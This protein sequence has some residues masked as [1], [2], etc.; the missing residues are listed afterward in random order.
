M[1]S[2]LM[3]A[4]DGEVPTKQRA[5]KTTTRV[6]SPR[7]CRNL[8]RFQPCAGEKRERAKR[9]KAI[10]AKGR[11]ASVGSL[12]PAKYGRNSKYTWLDTTTTLGLFRSLLLHTSE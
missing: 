11:S 9:K 5:G 7:D 6:L 4:E 8:E 12:L 1:T 10:E 2:A 3:L